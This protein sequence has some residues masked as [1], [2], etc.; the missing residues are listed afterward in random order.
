MNLCY[1]AQQILEQAGYYTRIAASEE[2]FDFEDETLFGF[3]KVYSSPDLMASD[4]EKQQDSFLN[5]NARRISANAP[6]A[7]NAYSVFL[8]SCDASPDLKAALSQIEDDFR[9]TRKIARSNLTTSED[10]QKALY[11]LLGL[12]NRVKLTQTGGPNLHERLTSLRPKEVE[13]L[14]N[15]DTRQVI[16]VAQLDD[17]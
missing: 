9:G 15:N 2:G 7:W 5:R 4:W 10:L 3:V 11:P 16:S 12:V 17:P 13:A 14:L 1:D 8:S 6:K